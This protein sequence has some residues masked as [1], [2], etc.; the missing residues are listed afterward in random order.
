MNR[1]PFVK[2]H[3]TFP[4]SKFCAIRYCQCGHRFKK[5]AGRPCGTTRCAGFHASAGHPATHTDIELNVPTGRPVGTSQEADIEMDVPIGCPVGTTQNAGFSTSTG[6]PTAVIHIEMNVP[7][8][9]PVG[10]TRDPGFSTSTGHPTAD[11]DI[12]NEYTNWTS[13]WYNS[14]CWV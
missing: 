6:H 7:T 12:E 13:C 5:R 10:I 9:C 3:Q 1:S 2:I 8:G 4:P 11:V 14:R